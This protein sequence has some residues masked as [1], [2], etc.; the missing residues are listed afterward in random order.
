MLPHFLRDKKKGAQMTRAGAS[1]GGSRLAIMF[2]E[3][4]A[5]ASLPAAI[6]RS[7][8]VYIEESERCG[9][10]IRLVQSA[11]AGRDVPEAGWR[12]QVS[13]CSWRGATRDLGGNEFSF[14][15]IQFS[16]RHSTLNSHLIHTVSSSCRCGLRR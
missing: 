16:I 6:T 2:K 13:S 12:L 1:V 5:M 10:S 3:R 4:L 7:H 8:T 14:L 9:S 11:R 15:D